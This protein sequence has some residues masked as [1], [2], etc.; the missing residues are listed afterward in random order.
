MA[1]CFGVFDLASVVAIA[2]AGLGSPADIPR[3]HV[4]P[5]TDLH[6]LHDCYV[7]ET[8]CGVR[9]VQF[10]ATTGPRKC[11]RRPSATPHMIPLR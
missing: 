2:I 10:V 1:Y 5:L 11:D 3:E 9:C 8:R 6:G 7:G 4:P